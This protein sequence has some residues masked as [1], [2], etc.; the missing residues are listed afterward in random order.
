MTNLTNNQLEMALIVLEELID[1]LNNAK[2]SQI[3][4]IKKYEEEDE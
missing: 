3:E 2:Q 4:Q 1:Y